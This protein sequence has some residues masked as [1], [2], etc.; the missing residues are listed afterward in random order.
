MK[1]N[2][3]ELEYHEV[4]GLNK[5]VTE[6]YNIKNKSNQP[7]VLVKPNELKSCLSGI[8]AR[9]FKGYYYNFPIEKM[10]GLLLF[11]VAQ[12]QFFMDGNKRTAVLSMRFFLFNNGMNILIK[13]KDLE[14]LTWGFAVKK[15]TD[16]D[17]IEY[18]YDNISPIKR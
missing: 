5:N 10:A 2:L 3:S 12:G 11:R 14:E 18:V 4:V 9:D 17:S 7:H 13:G 6:I 16:L 1:K 15:Y 8:F